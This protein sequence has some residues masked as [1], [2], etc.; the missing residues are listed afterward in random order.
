[1]PLSVKEI[2]NEI[3]AKHKVDEF[4]YPNISMNIQVPGGLEGEISDIAQVL[5][6]SDFEVTAT[7]VLQVME[8]K[9]K[10]LTKYTSEAERQK[11]LTDY[12]ELLATKVKPVGT[13]LPLELILVNGLV[14]ILLSMVAKFGLSFA[15]EAG[16]ILARKVFDEDKKQ[17]EKLNMT[18]DEYR[19]LKTEAKVW[20]DTEG[21]KLVEIKKSTRVRKKSKSKS[22]K[23]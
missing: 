22:G 9:K 21:N 19:F 16:K 8:L 2:L 10:L 7:N 14:I 15:D 11:I 1:M 12:Q 20:V 18:E 5:K 17:S 23:K 13:V 4:F 3:K 6:S